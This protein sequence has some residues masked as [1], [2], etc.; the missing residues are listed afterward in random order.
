MERAGLERRSDEDPNK[1][2]RP[3]DKD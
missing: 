1:N 2:K 3:D